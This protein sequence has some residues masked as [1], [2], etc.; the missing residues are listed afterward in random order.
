MSRETSTRQPG[1]ARTPATSAVDAPRPRRPGSPLSRAAGIAKLIAGN[2]LVLLAIFL[3]LEVAARAYSAL[4]GGTFFRPRDFICPWITTNDDPPP[5]IDESGHAY[6]RH[7][8]SPTPTEAAAG[9][10]RIIAVGGSTTVNEH[11][12]KIAGIDYASELE[13][14]LR[15]T[16][17]GTRFEVLNAGGDGYSTA[18]S[19]INIE[20]RLV[21]FK[22]DII[23]VMHN[24]NDCS[25]N[26]FG[27]GATPDY[28]NKYL[29]P[30]F[31][32]PSLQGSLSLAG[33]L[34]Q[35]RLLVQLGL[36][37]LLMNKSGDLDPGAPHAPGIPYFKRNIASIAAVCREAG[38][39]LV[40]LTQPYSRQ[41]HPFVN[42]QSVLDY[43][44]AIVEVT[45]ELEIPRIDMFNLLGSRPDLF[46]D[47]FH[48]TP[49]GVRRF[50]AILATELS[51]M[52]ESLIEPPASEPDP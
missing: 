4:T 24:I 5:R 31:L 12:F 11:A 30:Y 42:P 44:R 20:F 7:R 52:I 22:P 37:R 45:D 51:P 39:R 19:L 15:E 25:V 1:A 49:D 13:E 10:I 9:T 6:F 33:F 43:N 23:L 27:G 35:S 34:A 50:G 41:P 48:Y 36:P 38:T 18:Q 29:K 47:P 14:R 40:V 26:F 32:S 2:V 16:F 17:D 3:V 28:S 46:I 8:S 21:E